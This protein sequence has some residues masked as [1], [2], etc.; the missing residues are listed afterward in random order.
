MFTFFPGQEKKP[1]CKVVTLT[2][3]NENCPFQQS[4]AQGIEAGSDMIETTCNQTWEDLKG[5]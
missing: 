4:V 1:I 3:G 2:T 5:K